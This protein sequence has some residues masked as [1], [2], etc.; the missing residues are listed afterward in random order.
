[1]KI[2]AKMAQVVHNRKS[3][4]QW[5]LA[6]NRSVP[7]WTL[8]LT[9]VIMLM[10]QFA[11]IL[12]IR[13]LGF[14][15]ELPQFQ[16]NSLLW[17]NFTCSLRLMLCLSLATAIACYRSEAPDLTSDLSKLEEAIET[18]ASQVQV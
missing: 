2:R 9:L 8:C 11:P 7:K 12:S 3:M 10:F 14:E 5:F 15:K 17:A 4:A 6:I 16:R 1:M 18:L 13:T